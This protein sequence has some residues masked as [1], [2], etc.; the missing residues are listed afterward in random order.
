MRQLLPYLLTPAFPNKTVGPPPRSHNHHPNSNRI[1]F[2]PCHVILYH[3]IP[4]HA[5]V[6]YHIILYHISCRTPSSRTRTTQVA[7]NDE[8]EMDSEKPLLAL[9]GNSYRSS[10]CSTVSQ[11]SSYSTYSV[12]IPKS[13]ICGVPCLTCRV[14]SEGS[15]ARMNGKDYII[16]PS[17]TSKLKASSFPEYIQRCLVYHQTYFKTSRSPSPQ[18]ND[19][20]SSFVNGEFPSRSSSIGPFLLSS[21]VLLVPV[22]RISITES[23]V[24]SYLSEY[25]TLPYSD[26]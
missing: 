20:P 16:I 7:R 23:K 17:Y 5:I 3:T 4:Y 2:P 14:N 19:I 9:L 6:S 25:L 1:P 18:L 24:E 21:T 15:P 8:V 13:L 26:D 12:Q 11:E 22:T 10:P